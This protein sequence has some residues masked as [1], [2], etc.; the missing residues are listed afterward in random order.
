MSRLKRNGYKFTPCMN[1]GQIPTIDDTDLCGPCCYGE[2]DS[3][4]DWLWEDWTGCRKAG[5]YA[6]SLLK[7]AR[8]AGLRYEPDIQKRLWQIAKE[9]KK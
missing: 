9:G 7:E 3:M 2:A 5:W 4:W 1:C 6:F 8:E